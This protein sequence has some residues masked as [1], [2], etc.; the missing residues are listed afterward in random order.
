MAQ[1]LPGGH[2]SGIEQVTSSSNDTL[3]QLGNANFSLPGVLIVPD[4]LGHFLGHVANYFG[5]GHHVPAVED[6]G[7]IGDDGELGGDRQY[8]VALGDAVVQGSKPESPALAEVR[9]VA[10]PHGRVLSRD[11]FPLGQTVSS[12]GTTLERD[13]SGSRRIPDELPGCRW[14]TNLSVVLVPLAVRVVIGI[15]NARRH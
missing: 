3:E 11:T 14:R 7:V 5:G 13:L 6:A 12:A 10:E 1:V 9:R 8:G 2:L 4:V 15:R